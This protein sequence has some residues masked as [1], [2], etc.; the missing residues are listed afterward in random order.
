MTLTTRYLK[1]GDNIRLTSLG[2]LQVRE[3]AARMGW[4][5]AAGRAGLLCLTGLDGTR[6]TV[7]A[8]KHSSACGACAGSSRWSSALISCV[9]H[10]RPAVG[11]GMAAKPRDKTL[12]V[13]RRFDPHRRLNC[14]PN[15]CHIVVAEGVCGIFRPD[16]FN[17][18][19]SS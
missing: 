11:R 2:I 12:V 14:K 7:E 4:N 10:E 15:Q 8:T 18:L 17:W 1:K 16:G 3:H 19:K 9:L 13:D 5:Q 6:W